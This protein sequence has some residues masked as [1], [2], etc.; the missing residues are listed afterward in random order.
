MRPEWNWANPGP[1]TDGRLVVTGAQA[2][3]SRDPTVGCEPPI[4]PN[5]GVGRGMLLTPCQEWDRISFK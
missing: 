2:R 5:F 4:G 1:E 3:A